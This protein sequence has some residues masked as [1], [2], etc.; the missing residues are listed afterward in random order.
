MGNG[1]EID[2]SNAN[3]GTYT[4][5]GNLTISAGTAN[6]NEA[7]ITVSG[8]TTI[9]GGATLDISHYIGTKTF[10]VVNI[11]AGGNWTVSVD[12]NGTDLDFNSAFSNLGTLT[13]LRGTYTFNGAVT[14][15]SGGII[16]VTT[17]ASLE[18]VSDLTNNG[19]TNFNSGSYLFHNSTIGGTSPIAFDGGVD[20]ASGATTIN[21]NSGGLTFNVSLEGL[22]VGSVFQNLEEVTYNPNSRDEPMTLGSLDASAIGNTFRYARTGLTQDVRGTTYYNLVLEAGPAN[23]FLNDA[24]VTVTGN[25]T[26]SVTQTGSFALILSGANNQVIAGGGTFQDMTVNKSGG[27]LSS[28]QNFNITSSL[29]MTNGV[30]ETGSTEINMGSA[31][32]ISETTTGYVTGNV[33]STRFI[34]DGG[35]SSFGGLG[36]TLT[37]SVGN[38]LGN[39]E[40]TRTTGSSALVGGILR[41]FTI[42]P[43]INSVLNSTM[44][45][46]YRDDEL[47]GLSEANFEL[48]ENTGGGFVNIGGAV[49]AGTNTVTLSGIGSFGIMT[50]GD[51]G[52]FPVEWLDFTA[53]PK[54]GNVI[55]EWSTAVE[56][57]NDFFSVERSIDGQFYSAVGKV[58]GAGTTNQ[59]QNYSFTD[60][61]AADLNIS[62]IFYRIRQVD[63]NGGYDYSNVVEVTLENGEF[64]YLDAYPSPFEDELKIQINLDKAD[65]VNLKMV[66]MSARIVF[67]KQFSGA[68][69]NNSLTFHGATLSPGIYVV[70]VSTEFQKKFL[71]VVK[72]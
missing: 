32:T 44:S 68:A 66:D 51:P 57:N 3:H 65:F 45:F 38:P 15:N 49:D 31:G 10:G 26:N 21:D 13:F 52:S 28:N 67:E 2:G 9:S 61:S 18:F 47:N 72:K 39:T 43:T 24:D 48:V 46:T 70:E 34:G 53:Y 22:G 59:I 64:I 62:T 50:V 11:E 4:V 54:R 17:N 7:V 63:Q 1:G 6:L 12:N 30:L 41:Y 33:K 14:N 56:I 60:F 8:T 16:N 27:T 5:S 35:N 58:K 20:V 71:R 19:T 36:L 37:A 25:L 55:L 29:T 42:T 69:G 40:V 23:R